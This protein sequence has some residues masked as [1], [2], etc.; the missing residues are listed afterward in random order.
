MV[1][2]LTNNYSVLYN[3]LVLATSQQKTPDLNRQLQASKKDDMITTISKNNRNKSPDTNISGDDNGATTLSLPIKRPP[4]P[5]DHR[6]G[7]SSP[8]SSKFLKPIDEKLE[9]TMDQGS[10]DL[11]YRKARVSVRARSE[12]PMVCIKKIKISI[13]YNDMRALESLFTIHDRWTSFLINPN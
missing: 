10:I 1:N 4:L 11:P 12:A 3:H 13:I 2:Q 8:S 9:S 6:S 7:P 5:I